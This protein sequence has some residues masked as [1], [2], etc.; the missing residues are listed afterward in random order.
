CCVCRDWLQFLSSS[1]QAEGVGRKETNLMSS[2]GRIRSPRPSLVEWT[3]NIR[4][5]PSMELDRRLE[6]C[7]T[8]SV[9]YVDEE[10]RIIDTIEKVQPLPRQKLHECLDRKLRRWGLSVESVAFFVEN[11]RTPLPDN[12]DAAYLAGHRIVVRVRGGMSRMG[13]HRPQFSVDM[14]VFDSKPPSRKLSADAV[15]RKASFTNAKV[16]SK[17][18]AQCSTQTTPGSGSQ[19]IQETR[20]RRNSSSNQPTLLNI[21][22]DEPSCSDVGTTTVAIEDGTASRRARSTANARKSIFFGKDKADMLSRLA[23]LRDELQKPVAMFELEEHWTLIVANH[24]DLSRR[25]QEQ[26]EAIWEFVT[27]EHRYLQLL[28]QMDELCRYFLRMQEVGYLRDIDPRRVFLNY[29][30]LYVHNSKFWKRAVMPMLEN[31]REHGV[32]L[33]PKMLKAGFDRIDEW[34][35]CYTA[36]INGHADCHAYV[37]KC[38]KEHEL[39][40]EFVAWAESQ[41]TL[42]RQ[43]LLDALTNPMQ[44][45]TRYS[46]LLKAVLRNSTDDNERETIQEMISRIDAAT[47][48]VEETLNNNDLQNKLLE[49]SRTIENYDAVDADEFERIF[50]MKCDIRLADPMPYIV[51]PPQFR[52]VYLR[53]DLKMK[54]GKQGAKVDT[55]CIVFTDLFLVCKATT[56]RAD[57][58]RILKP[59]MHIA[60]ICLQQFSDHSGF[61]VS[62]IN[63]F[64]MPTSL[65]YFF[66]PSIE[67]TRKWLEMTSMAHR[68]FYRLKPLNPQQCFIGPPFGITNGFTK[69]D[70]MLTL[71]HGRVP[72][73]GF[74]GRIYS[75][76]CSSVLSSDIVHRKSS[77][78]DSQIVAE[79]SRLANMRKVNTISSADHLDRLCYEGRHASNLLSR[80]KLSVSNNATALMNSSLLGQ[81]K[82]SVDLYLAMRSLDHFDPSKSTCRSRS[83]SLDRTK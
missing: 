43:R 12:C 70:M 82:S 57:R 80:Q 3:Q 20:S 40:R 38:Q 15:A 79:H 78:M 65:Y 64:G 23:A 77:S 75:D 28:K 8:F 73:S 34:W 68:D 22:F 59:P 17:N 7:S 47:R 81:S 58:L 42:R 24:A 37:Q 18:R 67:E 54:D 48:S 21:P 5:Y 16:L 69:L 49:L 61:A 66:T 14:E 53:G 33:D 25:S 39:F 29:P 11:S 60:R 62:A 55:H 35:P 26:Q 2:V 45:L 71:D 63:D 51:G 6:Q 83:N 76:H 13:R 9:E 56:K 50:R 36:F 52:R 31:T 19:E 44:R 32:P 1:R 27:T 30:E 41:D 74:P 4:R 46:L 72:S 10:G